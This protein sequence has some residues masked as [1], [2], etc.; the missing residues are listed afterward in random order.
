M[1]HINITN[2]KLKKIHVAYV[3]AITKSTMDKRKVF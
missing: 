1:F 2:V 3:I